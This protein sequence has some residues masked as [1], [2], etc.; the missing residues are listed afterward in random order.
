[1]AAAIVYGPLRRLNA[2]LHFPA[3]CH[4]IL[5]TQFEIYTIFKHPLNDSGGI[6]FSRISRLLGATFKLD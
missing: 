5:W 2:L 6:A 3:F 1:M 4:W